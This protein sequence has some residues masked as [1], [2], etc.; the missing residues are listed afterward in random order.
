MSLNRVCG[1]YKIQSRI[2]PER[3]YIGS[4]VNIKSRH[5]LHLRQ[6]KNNKHHSVKL[7]HHYNKYG[8]DDLFFSVLCV[9]EKE[10][11]LI[12]E[13]YYINNLNPW[14]N[15]SMIAGEPPRRPHTPEAIQKIKDARKKQVF[16]KES[17]LK[18]SESQKRYWQD[19]ANKE[20]I[21]KRNKKL[22]NSKKA[23]YKTA[24]GKVLIEKMRISGRKAREEQLRRQRNE[25]KN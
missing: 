16:S 20:K 3:I 1:I 8:A 23:L 13:Q 19:E 14:F 5:Y 7:Q 6:L 22:S 9:C 10:L 15:I 24:Y 11:L 2:K 17:R 4:A 25:N 12:K 18:A 21:A